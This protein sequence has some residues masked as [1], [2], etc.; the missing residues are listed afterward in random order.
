MS[1]PTINVLLY[2]LVLLGVFVVLPA[3]AIYYFF[4]H[5]TDAEKNNPDVC[6]FCGYDLRSSEGPC[7]EC[8][9]L[10]ATARFHRLRRLREEWPTDAIVPR[11]PGADETLVVVRESF[12]RMELDLLREHLEVRGIAGSVVDA[13]ELGPSIAGYAAPG[14]APR[15]TFKLAVW[16]A[17]ASTAVAVIDRLLSEVPS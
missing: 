11:R 6:E 8:G 13:P 5:V 15:G 1:P 14:H 7:P 4:R 16:S 3:L 17:D 2:L 10:G 9:S 12:D